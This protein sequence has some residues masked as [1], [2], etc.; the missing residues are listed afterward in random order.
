MRVRKI[1]VVWVVA[2]LAIVAMP[3]SSQEI[4][5]SRE[6]NWRIW[7]TS[8]DLRAELDYHWADLHLGDEWLLLKLSVAGGPAGGVTPVN[9][10]NIMVQAPDGAIT[11][12]PSQA[13]FR[14]VRGSMEVAFQQ[15]NSWGPSASRFRN[16]YVRIL[17]WFFSPPGATFHRE[18]ITPSA[19][20]YFSGPL[21]FQIPGGVQPGEWTLIFELEEM[22]AEIPFVLG[23]KN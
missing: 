11:M 8:P 14:A 5:V 17:E 4:E 19:R 23:G 2:V 15:E 12:L 16:S 10:K 13:E 22:R 1:L 7:Y 18:F 9:R 21:V 6:G 20:Q 3:V